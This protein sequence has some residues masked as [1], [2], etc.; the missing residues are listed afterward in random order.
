MVSLKITVGT[1]TL[2]VQDNITLYLSNT[3]TGPRMRSPWPA[4]I[5]ELTGE[6]ATELAQP[7]GWERAE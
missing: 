1:E 2:P 6:Q 4:A 3:L 7:S 5:L